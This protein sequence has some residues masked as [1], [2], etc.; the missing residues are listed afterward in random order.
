MCLCAQSIIDPKMRNNRVEHV[1]QAHGG[2]VYDVAIHRDMM[3]TS[4]YSTMA[5]PDGRRP[6]SDPLIKVFD[7]RMMRQIAPL[8]LYANRGPP[9]LVSFLPQ[10]SSSLVIAKPD[11]QLQVTREHAPI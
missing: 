9:P 4:G 5:T 7:L 10:F 8:Q 3:V 6:R 1:L 2:A 11:A